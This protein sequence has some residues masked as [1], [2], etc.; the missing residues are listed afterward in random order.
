MREGV[1]WMEYLAEYERYLKEDKKA[2]PNTLSS[3]LRDIRQY[4]TWLES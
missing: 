1:G 2:L 4:L 3:Y